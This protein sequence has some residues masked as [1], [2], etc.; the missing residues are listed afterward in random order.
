MPN[1]QGGSNLFGKRMIVHIKTGSI[2][3]ETKG[4][5]R[6]PKEIGAFNFYGP[7]FQMIIKYEKKKWSIRLRFPLRLFFISVFSRGKKNKKINKVQKMPKE[8]V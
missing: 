6:L 7:K 1:K 4:L 3:Q 8:G 2:K 5:Q